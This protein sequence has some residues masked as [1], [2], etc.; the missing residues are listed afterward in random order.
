M[1]LDTIL[2]ILLIIS[3]Y[4]NYVLYQACN[5]LANEIADW[6]TRHKRMLLYDSHD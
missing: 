1:M 3:L 2:I 4:L 6:E 5:K